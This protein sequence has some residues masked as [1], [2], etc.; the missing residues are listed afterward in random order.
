MSEDNPT[1]GE[2]AMDAYDIA[3]AETKSIPKAMEAAAQAVAARVRA[4][5]IKECE[6]LK[7]ALLMYMDAYPHN[8]PHDCF[9]T[10]PR[11]GDHFLDLVVCPGCS[12]EKMANKALAEAKP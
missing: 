4:E 5:T 12:A 9:A 2:T 7:S 10:G 8:A 3:W 11:T 6:T 1:L